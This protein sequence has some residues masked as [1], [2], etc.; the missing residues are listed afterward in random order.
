M[1][2]IVGFDEEAEVG[3]AVDEAGEFFAHFGHHEL[4]LFQADHFALGVLGASA[5]RY[6]NYFSPQ[7]Y[8][9]RREFSIL[10]QKRKGHQVRKRERHVSVRS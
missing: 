1:K 8:R 10:A 7:R 2:K 6:L 9:I 5:V 4:G 3:Q